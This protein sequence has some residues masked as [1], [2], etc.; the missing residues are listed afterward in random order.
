MDASTK[1]SENKGAWP[2]GLRLGVSIGLGIYLFIVFAGPATRPI[3]SDLT[4]PISR[5]LEPIHQVLN[6]GHGYRFFAPDPGPSHILTYEV[7]LKDGTLARGV[8]PD[9]DGHWPRLLYHRWFMLSETVYGE[10]SMTPD[11]E[12]YEQTQS[13]MD[14]QIARLRSAG[15]RRLALQLTEEKRRHAESFENSKRR[16]ELL[17]NSIGQFLIR[18]HE[19]EW[20]KLSV[21]ERPIPLPGDVAMGLELGDADRL[22]PPLRSWVIEATKDE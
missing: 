21:Q 7:G 3:S 15:K 12:S 5:G 17:L 13:S 19:G 1:M 10:L 9:R 14:D 8:F 6:L 20:I 2:P 18:K 4:A 22:T 11:P 16:I